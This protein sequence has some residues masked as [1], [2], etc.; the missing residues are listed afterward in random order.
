MGKLLNVITPLHKNTTRDYL[1]RMMQEK[2]LC[3]RQAREF[4][5]L[6]W[7]GDRKYGYGGYSYDGRWLDVAEKLCQIY[8][9]AENANILDVGCGKGYLLFDFTQVIQ[10]ANVCGFDISDYAVKNSKAEIKDKLIVADA[11][12]N[13][14]YSD[15]QFDVAVSLTTLH[16]LALP[17][18]IKGLREIER[19]AR[20]KYI[21]V[22]SYRNEKELFNL[23]CWTLTCNSFYTPEEWEYVFE[24]AGYSGDYEFIYFE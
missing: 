14:P 2:V 5:K 22:D 18:L 6:F 20:Q 4:G 19:V 8:Q 15:N 1:D 11:A 3:M 23:Q 16:N 7:D 12:N 17:S 9:L 13:Y 10:N 24:I 21:V